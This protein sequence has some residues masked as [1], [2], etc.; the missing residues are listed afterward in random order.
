MSPAC[1]R[2][3]A[4]VDRTTYTVGQ[5]WFNWLKFWK[6]TFC[7]FGEIFIQQA[8]MKIL[9][10]SLREINTQVKQHSKQNVLI[11]H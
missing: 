9:P 6:Y 3:S 8:D 7:D 4:D 2:K 10:N 5:A 1:R 11:T